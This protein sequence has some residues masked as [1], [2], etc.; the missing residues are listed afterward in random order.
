LQ[1]P[2]WKKVE[3]GNNGGSCLNEWS[4]RHLHPNNT[5]GGEGRKRE[6]QGNSLSLA[7]KNI[8][9]TTHVGGGE[10]K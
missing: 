1:R 8:V 2:W 6:D 7:M 4:F 10:Q 5:E 9:S 3:V